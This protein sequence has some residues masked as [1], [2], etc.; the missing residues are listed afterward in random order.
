LFGRLRRWT[1]DR[2]R[3][4]AHLAALQLFGRQFGRSAAARAVVTSAASFWR[5]LI[6]EIKKKASV[7]A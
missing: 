2:G 3:D 7:A 5:I 6:A 1:R 4:F